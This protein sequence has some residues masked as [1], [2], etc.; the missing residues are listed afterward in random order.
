[1]NIYNFLNAREDKPWPDII[2]IVV[3]LLQ[4]LIFKGHVMFLLLAFCSL[5]LPQT[6]PCLHF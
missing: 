4:G 6:A 3:P 2:I 1:M 5:L